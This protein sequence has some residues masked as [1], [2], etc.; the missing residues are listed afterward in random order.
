MTPTD[1]IRRPSANLRPQLLLNGHI[2]S[3][4][5]RLS[6]PNILVMLAQTSTGL[7]ETWWIC[8]LGAD[9]L[10]GIAVVFPADPVQ[11]RVFYSSVPP[12]ELESR[13]RGPTSRS[14]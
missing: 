3:T 2:V 5:F 10:A 13:R 6:W 9:A 4:L 7:V 8:R 11:S 12:V 1:T 14:V